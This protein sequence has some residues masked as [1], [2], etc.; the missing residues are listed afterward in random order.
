VIQSKSEASSSKILNVSKS[1]NF[2][3]KVMTNCE[4]KTPK[5][6]IL[7]RPEP[8]SQVLKNSKSVVLKPKFQRRKTTVAFW[9]S[10]PKVGKSKVMNE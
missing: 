4:S 5:I 9:D 2:K 7:K 3:T 8:K 6:Q 1:K 10:K